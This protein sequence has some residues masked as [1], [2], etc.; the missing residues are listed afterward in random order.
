M[1]EESKLGGVPEETAQGAAGGEKTAPPET[2]SEEMT[3]PAEERELPTETDYAALAES[4][5]AEIRRL[6]PTFGRLGHL[7]EMPNALRYATLRDAGLTVEEALHAACHA[8]LMQPPADNRAH[9]RS[10]VPIGA[11][12]SP[13]RMTATELRDAR[14]L[15]GDLTDA[16]LERLY[17]KCQSQ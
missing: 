7:A 1:E 15:F 16:E 17:A 10:A 9:L 2:P 8:Y 11:A 4:D 14:E 3:A 12:G 13:A 6:A 5:L